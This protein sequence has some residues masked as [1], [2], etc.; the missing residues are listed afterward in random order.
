MISYNIYTTSIQTSVPCELINVAVEAILCTYLIAVGEAE[1]QVDMQILALIVVM[2][3]FFGQVY[4]FIVLFDHTSN[5][6]K[7]HLMLNMVFMPQAGI[8]IF[9]SIF[10]PLIPESHM[11]ALMSG[12][13]V[14]LFLNACLVAALVMSNRSEGI[15]RIVRRSTY[16]NESL[17]KV[18][19]SF[20]TSS[21][22]MGVSSSPKMRVSSSPKSGSANTGWGAMSPMELDAKKVTLF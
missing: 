18:H 19:P 5:I 6:V 14:R 21:P 2:V 1:P 12:M 20:K 8:D 10:E 4:R 15:K 9:L 7:L 16:N 22:K 3:A 17:A 13:C 11:I